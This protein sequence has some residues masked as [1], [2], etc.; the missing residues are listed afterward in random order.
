MEQELAA[1]VVE[2]A[3]AEVGLAA[4]R[5]QPGSF[6][7]RLADERRAGH[8]D[9]AD[10]GAHSL[11][12]KAFFRRPRDENHGRFCRYL[13]ERNGRMYGVHHAVDDVARF[14]GMGTSGNFAAA[15]SVARDG[16][17]VFVTGT[18]FV[19]ADA[20]SSMATV[21]YNA[22]A[23][24][25]LWVAR[26]RGPGAGGNTGGRRDPLVTGQAVRIRVHGELHWSAPPS[27]AAL[28]DQ[29]WPGSCP[30]RASS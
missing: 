21:A 20:T 14:S 25:Q 8:H 10:R 15:V 27:T 2:A 29:P 6:L 7:V 22:S 18:S 24:A 12:V 23:G 11:L 1:A 30:S 17:K 13:L 5:P 26:F 28:R 16:T 3:P 4:Q 19:A 9:L